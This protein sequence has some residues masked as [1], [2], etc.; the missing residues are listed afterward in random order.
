MAVSQVKNCSKT[1]KG[2]SPPQILGRITTLRANLNTPEQ[3]GGGFMV[4]PSQTG[5]I[6][7]RVHSCGY[8]ESVSVCVVI[9]F[10]HLMIFAFAAGAG[11]S[12]LWYIDIFMF[13]LQKLISG[14]HPV[15][16]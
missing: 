15:P 10:P 6:L 13:S 14:H 5:N 11:K 9:I 8:T 16:R 1:F 12:I 3:Q 7:A 2:G 4:K